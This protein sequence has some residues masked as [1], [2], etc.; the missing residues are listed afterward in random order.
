M[1]GF[2]V[3]CWLAA[4]VGLMTY[5]AVIARYRSFARVLTSSGL[6]FTA[7]ALAVLPTALGAR[8]DAGQPAEGWLV[9]LFL[10]LAL[11]AQGVAALRTRPSREGRLDRAI[12]SAGPPT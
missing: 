10:I 3:A 5:G 11:L 9:L 6:F 1:S 12:D 2:G 8:A 7:A 4:A